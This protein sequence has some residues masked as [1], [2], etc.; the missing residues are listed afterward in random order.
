M[1]KLV[2][3]LAVAAAVL[4]AC[5]KAENPTGEGRKAVKFTVENLGTF[6]LRSATLGIG[7]AGCSNVGIYA[8]TLGANNVQATVSGSTLTPATPIYW[9]VGQTTATQFV[10]RYPHANDGTI[11]GTYTISADQSAADDF[12]YHAN[13]MSAVQSATPDPGTV[14]FNFTHP[15]AKVVVNVTN[16]LGADAVASVVLQNIR[17]TASSLD[18]T[19]APATTTINN[20]VA[21]VNV[22]AYSVSATQFAMIVLPQAVNE[23]MNIVVTTT[24]GSVYTFR[25]TNA[26]YNFLAGKISTAAVTLNPIGGGAN[27]RVQVGAMTFTTTDWTDGA[28]TTIGTVGDPSLGAYM[29]IGGTLFTDDDADAVEAGTLNAWGKWYNMT[30]S[31]ANTWTITVNYRESM[32]DDEGGKGFLIRTSDEAEYYK[33]YDGSENIGNDP[34]VLY[35]ENADHHKNV[36]LVSA[37][38]KY[39]I[40]YNSSTHAVSVAAAE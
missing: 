13:L 38:G 21:A 37:T 8:A 10:A 5:T 9:G 20:E 17:Q 18:M 24:L 33:M 29:Q 11:N 14:A 25:I 7:E 23:N 40:T 34:Y 26:E 4:C 22:T 35:T 2:L 36:R 30:Y 15:F 32:A 1:K 16:N 28:A 12:T 27:N 39:T 3:A 6:T 31:A 19:T